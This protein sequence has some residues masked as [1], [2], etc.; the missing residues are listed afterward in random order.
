MNTIRAITPLDG[1]YATQVSGL[2][3]HLSEW[4]L[5]RR[6]VEVEV[7]WLV[8]M[9]GCADIA[10]MR[11]LTG[12]EQDYLRGLVVDFDD[13]AAMR[14]KGIERTTNHDVKAVGILHPRAAGGDF[15][16]RCWRVGAFLLHI[17]G[18]QQFVARADGSRVRWW[19]S[20][21]RRRAPLV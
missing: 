4:A 14:V 12:A 1:R 15:A 17:G 2:A 8:E 3:E 13:D 7:E 6:R 9:A 19:T 21:C 5:I 18:H 20:G 10:D 11:A 16:G